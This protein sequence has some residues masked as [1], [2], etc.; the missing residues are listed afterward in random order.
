MVPEALTVYSLQQF[1]GHLNW[2]QPSSGIP[3]YAMFPLF[4][5]SQGNEDPTSPCCFSPQHY[6]YYSS[7]LLM[8]NIFLTGVFLHIL[9][10]RFFFHKTYSYSNTCS[11]LT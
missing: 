6:A 1:L 7:A 8:P 11:N 4:Q 2:V 10:H 9:F 5:L 3:A